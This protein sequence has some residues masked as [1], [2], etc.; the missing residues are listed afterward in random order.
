MNLDVKTTSI[1][2][3]Y[4][5]MLLARNCN[6]GSYSWLLSKCKNQSSLSTVERMSVN[7]KPM[8]LN[9]FKKYA[10]VNVDGGFVCINTLRKELHKKY[11]PR[12]KST[13]K[14]KRAKDNILSLKQK[15]EGAERQRAV[16]L[17]AYSELNQIAVDAIK[18][19]PQNEYEY[20]KHI[21]LYSSF[22]GLKVV[23][24]NG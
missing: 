9:T 22:F 4:S 1:V 18:N 20:K 5:E 16:L 24:N 14:K 12:L 11:N 2:S 10:D 8:T 3:L 19:S 23:V 6:D 7:I 17:R 15:L 13:Q 21:K